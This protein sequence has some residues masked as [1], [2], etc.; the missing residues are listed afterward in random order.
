MEILN[1]NYEQYTGT[2]IYALVGSDGKR[3]IGKALNF[4]QRMKQHGYELERVA[5]GKESYHEGFKLCQAVKDGIK[6]KAEI[7]EKVPFLKNTHNYLCEREQYY[8]ELYGGANNT[9]NSTLPTP[10]NENYEPYNEI[11]LCLDFD[12]DDKELVGFL[13]SMQRDK[14]QN[15]IKDLIRRDIAKI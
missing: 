9:Y 8:Y 6:F 11:I 15:Y 2:V 4:V 14:L 3:Y 7:L 13:K 5:N 12:K 10:A 1:S